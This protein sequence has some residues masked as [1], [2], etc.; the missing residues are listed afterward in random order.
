MACEGAEP[1]TATRKILLK[2]GEGP[3]RC[4]GSPSDTTTSPLGIAC[5]LTARH[6]CAGTA[7]VDLFPGDALP[8]VC[9]YG[10]EISPSRD[11]KPSHYQNVRAHHWYWASPPP[12]PNCGHFQSAR[13]RAN[14][15]F[16]G[17]V[18]GRFRAWSRAHLSCAHHDGALCSSYCICTRARFVQVFGVGSH[19]ASCFLLG[20]MP[21]RCSCR[22][23]GTGARKEGICMCGRPQGYPTSDRG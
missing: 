18:G 15:P 16:R 8:V 4:P 20:G 10:P 14:H 3:A 11:P 5:V 6:C 21:S 12:T 2:I 19:V 17:G 22:K 23:R 13:A 9:V 7:C 1:K